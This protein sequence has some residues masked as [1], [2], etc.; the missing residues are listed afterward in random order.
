MK[1]VH[2]VF[3]ND[4]S[5]NSLFSSKKAASNFCIEYGYEYKTFTV[6]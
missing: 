6:D 5:I 2:I 1:K 3:N 4:G